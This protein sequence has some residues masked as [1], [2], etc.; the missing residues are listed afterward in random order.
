[1]IKVSN[2]SIKY[3]STGQTTVKNLSF[4]VSKG[5]VV[6]F[7]GPS[8]C[9]KTTLLSYLQGTLS[10]EEI[11]TQ[12]T[13][14]VDPSVNMIRTVFQEPR[15]LPWKTSLGNVALGLELEGV[16]EKE[17]DKR[18]TEAL[19]QIGLSKFRTTYPGQLSMGMKQRVNFARAIVMKPQLL[20]LDEPFSA[21][22]DETKSQLL[23]QFVR[24]IKRS[25]I[26]TIFVTHNLEEA[27]Q[28][29]D[30]IIMLKQDFVGVRNLRDESKVVASFDSAMDLES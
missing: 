14:S 7:M 26:T 19:K 10:P 30:R 28:I 5:E 17:L 29:A 22:D 23:K 18:A 24:V 27:E 20:L 15:L 12:G 2:F 21:L 3:K 13:V 9:G 8:G 25:N 11:S 16:E 1:M 4:T 6:A